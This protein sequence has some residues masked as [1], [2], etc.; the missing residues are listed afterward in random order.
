MHSASQIITL[1]VIFIGKRTLK[2]QESGS[3]NFSLS[4]SSAPSTTSLAT[5]DIFA[6]NCVGFEDL[7]ASFFDEAFLEGVPTGVTRASK[8]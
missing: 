8:F 4:N 6:S 5:L 2:Y 1:T 7:A 3:S